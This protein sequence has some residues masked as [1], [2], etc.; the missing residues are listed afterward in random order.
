MRSVNIKMNKSSYD[1]QIYFNVNMIADDE[2]TI[3][4][5]VHFH[6]AC[7]QEMLE[8][9]CLWNISGKHPDFPNNSVIALQQGFEPNQTATIH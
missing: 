6:Q 7:M 4:F 5:T 1:R 9:V 2:K 8:A 3:V